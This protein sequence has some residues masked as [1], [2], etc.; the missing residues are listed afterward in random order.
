VMSTT[1]S[2]TSST[3]TARVASISSRHRSEP[4]PHTARGASLG[5]MDLPHP[6]ARSTDKITS[7]RRCCVRKGV[8]RENGWRRR[9]RQ[10]SRLAR[11][12][13]GVTC[14]MRLRG[15]HTS[16]SRS[17]ARTC[18]TGGL[19]MRE[20]RRARADVFRRGGDDCTCLRNT[21]RSV[22]VTNKQD[23][24]RI[25]RRVASLLPMALTSRPR[26]PPRSW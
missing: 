18:A 12:E 13:R 26:S 20:T 9:E 4:R 2:S 25:R 24:R 11:G 14:G 5:H 6:R 16:R 19:P 21:W 10:S 22:Q 1:P 17:V 8:V 7:R 3:A 23:V 15:S